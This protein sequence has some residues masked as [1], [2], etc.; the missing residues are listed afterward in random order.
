LFEHCGYQLV[1]DKMVAGL[2]VLALTTPSASALARACRRVGPNPGSAVRGGQW[3]VGR[4]TMPGAFWR[5]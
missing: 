3:A 2:R 4:P 1:W 5:G